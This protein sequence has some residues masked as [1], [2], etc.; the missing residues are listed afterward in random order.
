[1]RLS[2]KISE[3]RYSVTKVPSLAG[4]EAARDRDVASLAPCWQK[5]NKGSPTAMARH[6]ANNLGDVIADR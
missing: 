4:W 6:K 1:M 3:T 2:F 5:E